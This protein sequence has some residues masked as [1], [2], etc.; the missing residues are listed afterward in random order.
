MEGE[1]FISY[2]ESESPLGQRLMQGGEVTGVKSIASRSR[3]EVFF[4]GVGP[5]RQIFLGFKVSGMETAG[6]KQCI[7]AVEKLFHRTIGVTTFLICRSFWLRGLLHLSFV[8]L[9][10]GLNGS[11]CLVLFLHLR[12]LGIFGGSNLLKL[13]L[14][15]NLT[16]AIV[17]PCSMIDAF[18]MGRGL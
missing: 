16:F 18:S 9:C 2:S 10:L 14:K 15:A 4:S 17:N 5:L 12:F 1:N 11:T 6:A 8:S 7:L 3:E 13:I